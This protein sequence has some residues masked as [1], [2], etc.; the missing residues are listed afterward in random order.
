MLGC[1]TDSPCFKIAPISKLEG[2]HG[3][4]QLTVQTYGGGLWYTWFDRDLILAGKV[5]V[6]KEGKL[7]SMLWRSKH[8]IARIADLCIHLR[9]DRSGFN[10]NKEAET[11]PII[12]TA[13]MDQL[14][15]QGNAKPTGEDT[16][17]LEGK[18]SLIFLQMIATDLGVQVEDL[19]DFQLNFVDVQDADFIGLHKEFLVGGRLDNLIS[20]LPGADGLVDV[21]NLDNNECSVLLL[22]DNEEIGSQSAQ[23]ADS[24]MV[25]EVTERIFSLIKPS[26]TKD[27]YFRSIRKSLLLSCDVAHAIHPNY[28]SYH[29]AQH[30]PQLQ[31]GVVLK[32]NAN[33]RYMTDC[34]GASILRQ[35]AKRRN[36]PTQDFIVKNDSPCGSTIGPMMAAKCGMKTIDIGPPLLSMHSV[37]E[38][39]GV[40]DVLYMKKIFHA[41]FNDFSEVQHTLLDE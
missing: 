12:S 28:A 39:A 16:Y 1:H 9:T 29:Q 21:T 34:V 27:D 36:V 22:F 11:K 8:A 6:K 40:L 10:P 26:Y 18:H 15:G 31:K 38:Q 17:E 7:Q 4:T 35:L 24:N 3:F 20:S 30:A 32:I 25:C 33:Q 37:R 41:F 23:G 19:V 13:I 2:R 14:F 5:I